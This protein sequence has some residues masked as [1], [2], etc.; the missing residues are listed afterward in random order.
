MFWNPYWLNQR[1]ISVRHQKLRSWRRKSQKR[2]KR[3]SKFPSWT[4]YIQN[5]CLFIS[6]CIIFV[7]V[8]VNFIDYIWTQTGDATVVSEASI[9]TFYPFV[10]FIFYKKFQVSNMSG[11]HFSERK[12]LWNFM[13]RYGMELNIKFYYCIEQRLF[14]V[15]S[16][17]KDFI[18]LLC[19]SD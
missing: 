8:G 5:I 4:V 6:F 15:P 2:I 3:R 9:K 11:H 14:Y 7:N 1:Y 13:N 12:M 10:F 17:Y 18:L 19:F 16:G